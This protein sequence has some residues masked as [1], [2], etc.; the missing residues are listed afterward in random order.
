MFTTSMV[1]KVMAGYA[2]KVGYDTLPNAYNFFASKSQLSE[3]RK[4]NIEERRAQLKIE[5]DDSPIV[6]ILIDELLAYK[7]MPF[8]L[9]DRYLQLE[10]ILDAI[11]KAKGTK[12]THELVALSEKVIKAMSVSP[13]TFRN[14]FLER[15]QSANQQIHQLS[16]SYNLRSRL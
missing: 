10:Q 7:P 1:T 15:L 14:A 3:K 6:K 9:D 11:D 4:T 12:Q 13:G 5:E 16:E 8:T 2:A